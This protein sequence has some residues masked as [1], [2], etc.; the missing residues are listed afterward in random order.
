MGAELV[1]H[2][3]A[4]WRPADPQAALRLFHDM[5]RQRRSVRE[6]SSEPVPRETV[7]LLV[8]CA[9]TAPSGANKQPWRFACV[10]DPELK[11]RIRLAAEEEER[12]FYSTRASERWLK[13]LEPLGTD[14][15]KSFLE[16]APWLVA[17]FRLARG[18]D[19]S[20]TYY[21]EESAGI[22][23]GMFLAAAQAAGLAT[24]THTPSPMGF[25]QR[26]LGRGPH[27]KP[28][29]LV[30]LG[31]AA[32]GARVP[33]AALERKPLEQVLTWHE[34]EPVKET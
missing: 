21:S 4:D 11:R 18:D 2:P 31:R 1:P 29:V 16:T 24:L 28:F 3:G 10:S 13:D 20:Q 30:P 15:D 8:R 33:K 12:A 6:F 17:V 25:L 23:V 5:L 34:A 14:A 32:P 26:I 7:E 19:G 27:E 9:T 22:A